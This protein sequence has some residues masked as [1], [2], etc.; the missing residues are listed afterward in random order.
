M[1]G[2]FFK[3]AEKMLEMIKTIVVLC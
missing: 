2:I 3:I 1:M